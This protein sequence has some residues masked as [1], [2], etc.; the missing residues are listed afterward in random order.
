[1]LK[2]TIENL[3]D[4]FKFSSENVIITDYDFNI[5]W[6][7]KSEDFFL[8]NGLTCKELFQGENLPLKSGEYNVKHNGLIFS[9]RIINYPECENGVYVIQTDGEDIMF[10]FIKCS[11]IKEFLIN[12]AGAVRQAVTGITFSSNMLHKVL[13][14]SDLYS[15]HK[16]LDITMGN[17]YKLL[18]TVVNTTELI[19]YTDGSI[20]M[21]KIDV[22]A[23]LR[24]FTKKCSEILKRNIEIRME[25]EDELYIKA[26]LERF[27][28][29]LLSLTVLVNGKDP[30][31]NIIIFNAE[32]IGGFVSITVKSDRSGFDGNARVFA[33]T[34]ELYEGDAVDSDLFVVSRF[35]KTFNGTLF[36]SGS[37][38]DL[39][40][41]SLKFP[42][43]DDVEPIAELS[44][45]VRPYPEDKFSKYFI[46]LSE[47]ADV[48]YY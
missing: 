2:N 14:E 42:Y 15:D 44:A 23:V 4:L 20:V 22:S 29:C 1:M 38:N 11:G 26:D 5:L 28:S 35:C 36:V 21:K 33:R 18:K 16:Y 3:K 25:I 8:I 40:C 12:Q 7:N 47:I 17:C 45:S 13:E 30:E 24:E 31:N 6:N 41:F 27:V 37:S 48:F 39:K 19:R 43:C 34:P 32:R 46:V 9:C 10:S